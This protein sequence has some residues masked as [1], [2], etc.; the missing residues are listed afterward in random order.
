MPAVALPTPVPALRPFP[1]SLNIAATLAPFRHGR[2]DPTTVLGA[3]GRGRASSGTF[4]HATYTPD[5]P[6]TVRV[7]WTGG[8]RDIGSCDIDSYGSGGEWLAARVPRMLGSG[9]TGLV[10]VD[11]AGWSPT[12]TTALHGS[13]DVAIGASCNLYHELLPTIVEQRITGHEAHRQWRRL[14]VELSEP[15]PG[16]FPGLLLPPAPERLVGRPAWW[17]HP[18][19][20]ERKRAMP[21]AEI[22][23]HPARL[24]EWAGL[25]PDEAATKLRLLPGVGVWTVGTVLATALGD[26]DAVAVGDYHLKNV[27][28]F[29]LAGEARA[30]DERMLELLAPYSGQRGRVVR[31][32]LRHGYRAPKFGPRQRILPMSRW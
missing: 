32:L 8:R 4:L 19:G 24:W 28:G 30:T 22:A 3:V 10:G 21:L 12:V 2:T 26:P 31:A 20:I 23:R 1:T 17:F 6:G 11:T 25:P 16:P 14:C 18:L 7:R 15:A 9:D 13:N 29:A 5:G 27:V